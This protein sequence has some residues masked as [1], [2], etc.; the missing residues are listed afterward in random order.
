MD[1]KFLIIFSYSMYNV[2][3]AS[4]SAFRAISLPCAPTMVT[5]FLARQKPLRRLHARVHPCVEPC[6]ARFCYTLASLVSRCVKSIESVTK[7]RSTF[8]QFAH[9]SVTW[10][11]FNDK[12]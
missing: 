1:H 7:S 5:S 4:A 8:K 9:S 11:S 6:P 10:T 3:M 12:I 2:A